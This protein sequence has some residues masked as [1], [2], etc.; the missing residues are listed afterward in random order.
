MNREHARS[1]DELGDEIATLAAHIHA[2]MARW[3]AL[4]AEFDAREGWS[5]VGF[6]SCPEW[7][8]WRCSIDPVTARTHVRIARRLVELPLTAAAFARGELSYSK[9]RALARVEDVER[10]EELV[11]LARTTTAAQLDR[12]V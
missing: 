10:E 5:A 11:E 9:V 3:L 2:A 7:L 1:L 8:S 12:V 6:R 4:V